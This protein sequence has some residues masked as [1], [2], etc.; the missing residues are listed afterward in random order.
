MKEGIEKAD[1]KHYQKAEEKWAAKAASLP[2]PP[3]SFASCVVETA[4]RTLAYTA[5]KDIAAPPRINKG[6]QALSLETTPANKQSGIM[7]IVA[8]GNPPPVTL[9]DSLA[10]T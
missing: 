4:T 7:L 3:T 5:T 1:V 8:G 9:N 10:H 6:G 2:P